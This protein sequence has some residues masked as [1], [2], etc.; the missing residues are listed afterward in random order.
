M[1]GQLLMQRGLTAGVVKIQIC[2]S[3]FSNLADWLQKNAILL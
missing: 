3:L 1:M 2:S